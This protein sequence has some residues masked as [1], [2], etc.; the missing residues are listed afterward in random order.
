MRMLMFGLTVALAAPSFAAHAGGGEVH[1]AWQDS[2]RTADASSQPQARGNH[3][4][5]ATRRQAVLEVERAIRSGLWR[6]MTNN[7]G[8]CDWP[9]PQRTAARS[10]SRTAIEPSS[11]R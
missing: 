3:D 6:C 8:W 5:T 9:Q 7:R 10:Q 2:L 4:S 11:Q 1:N